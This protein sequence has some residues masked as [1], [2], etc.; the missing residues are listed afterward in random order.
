M[1][2]SNLKA[3]QTQHTGNRFR[4]R[5]VQLRITKNAK[6]ITRQRCNYNINVI[7]TKKT[8]VKN[9]QHQ[10]IYRFLALLTNTHSQ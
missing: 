4:H 7:N 6:P 2:H 1:I 3:L 10:K 5:N 9:C 8:S